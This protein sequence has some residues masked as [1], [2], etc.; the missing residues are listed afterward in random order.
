M[1]SI[2]L[3]AV[4]ALASACAPN[5]HQTPTPPARLDRTTTLDD[6][7]T[8]TLRPDAET[9]LGLVVQ[10]VEMANLPSSTRTAGEVMVADGRDLIVAAPVGGRVTG[11]TVP[12]AGERV[13]AGQALLTLVPL[14]SVDRDVGARAARDLEAARAEHLLAE[15]RVARAEAMAADR[16]GSM[17]ALEEARALERT[18]QATVISSEARI[19]TLESGTLDADVA[20]SIKSPVDGWLRAVRVSN[21]QSVP[22]GAVLFEVASAGRWIR[23]ALASS[24]G[25]RFVNIARATATRLGGETSIAIIPIV[26]PPSADAL[27][28]T[29]DRYFTAP[30]I[31]WV[32]G[33][34]VIVD[35]IGD[36]TGPSAITVPSGALVRDAEGGTWVYTRTDAHRFKRRRV[37]VERTDSGVAVLRGGLTAGADVVTTGAAELWGF[38]MGADR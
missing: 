19:R 6:L 23:A 9:A 18:T 13:R 3:V 20:L 5:E 11:R 12:R 15:Q 29:V 22:P 32:P 4:T 25:A 31:D 1:K 37:D 28:G 27:R 35:I 17:R 38:E 2:L 14:A 8:V 21:G 26:G 24:D 30:D 16:S 33:E 34:R 10:R 7:T 36:T